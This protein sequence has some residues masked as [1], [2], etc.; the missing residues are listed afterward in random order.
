MFM[1]GKSIRQLTRRGD[2]SVIH[3]VKQLLLWE[4]KKLNYSNIARICSYPPQRTSVGLFVQLRPRCVSSCFLRPTEQPT[5]A[6]DGG[7]SAACH[8]RRTSDDNIFRHKLHTGETDDLAGFCNLPGFGCMPG[9]SGGILGDFNSGCRLFPK[10]PGARFGAAEWSSGG[11]DLNGL[12]RGGGGDQHQTEVCDWVKSWKRAVW[13]CLD[14]LPGHWAP[15][16]FVPSTWRTVTDPAPP[17][18]A[19]SRRPRALCLPQRWGNTKPSVS[20]LTIAQC[21]IYCWTSRD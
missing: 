15:A 12:T 14:G 5:E 1:R 18:P 3:R 16:L 17:S 9:I 19:L 2:Y 7:E 20:N 11:G 8:L 21:I 13:G 6:S 10:M 4:E